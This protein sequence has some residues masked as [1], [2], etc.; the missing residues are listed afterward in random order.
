MLVVE[1]KTVAKDI[2]GGG[3]ADQLND[4][5]VSISLLEYKR[6]MDHSRNMSCYPKSNRNRAKTLR[7]YDLRNSGQASWGLRSL[8]TSS[9]HGNEDSQNDGDE[10]DV[11]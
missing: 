5:G 8:H 1:R 2:S 9:D 6:R 10:V 7:K 11:T 3:Q 4:F